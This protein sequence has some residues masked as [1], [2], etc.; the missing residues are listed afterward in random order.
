MKHSYPFHHDTFDVSLTWDYCSQGE[1]APFINCCMRTQIVSDST[2]EPESV[3]IPLDS[4]GMTLP[5]YKDE[6]ASL[7]FELLEHIMGILRRI[8]E[9]EDAM[10]A[11][12]CFTETLRKFGLEYRA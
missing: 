9:A 2:S 3:A 4:G 12:A 7:S 11:G 5:D 8:K 10:I 6:L 1:D